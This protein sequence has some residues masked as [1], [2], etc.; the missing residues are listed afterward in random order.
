MYLLI[1]VIN[2]NQ[3]NNLFKKRD[4]WDLKYKLDMY[5]KQRHV[6][7]KNFALFLSQQ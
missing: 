5:I 7:T 6:L 2:F 3:F 4:V 1:I